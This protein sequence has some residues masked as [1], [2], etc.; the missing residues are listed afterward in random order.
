MVH[1]QLIVV[2]LVIEMAHDYSIETRI[3]CLLES[4]QA[5]GEQPRTLVMN[6]ITWKQLMWELNGRGYRDGYFWTPQPEGSVLDPDYGITAFLGIPI[7]IKEFLPDQEVI[8][9]V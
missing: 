9:G 2:G 1:G 6:A 8:V 4:H 7:L 5:A 3:R